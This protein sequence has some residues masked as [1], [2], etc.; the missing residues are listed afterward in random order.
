MLAKPAEQ[1]PLI[2]A[3]A[4]ALLVAAGMSGAALQLLPGAGETIGAALVADARVRGV[5]FTGSNE[6]A[7]LLQRSLAGRMDARAVRRC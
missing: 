7:R 1:T 2:A 6:V 3:H 4:V 5:L